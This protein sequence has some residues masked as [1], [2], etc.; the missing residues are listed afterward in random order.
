MQETHVMTDHAIEIAAFKL[1]EG[2]SDPAFSE[3]QAAV[4]AFLAK[5]PGFI[6][7]RLSRDAQGQYL[8]HVEWS[9]LA[10]AEAAM[11]AS[12]AEPTLQRFMRMIDPA[13]L[14]MQHNVLR[15]TLG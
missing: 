5:Q 4:N 8:D 7:R 10:D 6:A 3:A 1:T 12:M 13:S 11:Q 15:V 9:S 2:V 14:S